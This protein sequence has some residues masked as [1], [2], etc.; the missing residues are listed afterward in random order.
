MK[1]SILFWQTEQRPSEVVVNF[2]LVSSYTHSKCFQFA[3]VATSYF[4]KFGV[5]NRVRQ[6]GVLSPILFAI[7]LDT[8]LAISQLQASDIVFI[9]EVY[10][11]AFA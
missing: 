5:S 1:H 4:D 11:G 6:D 10:V 3:R 7:Y 9:G 8:L 2:F